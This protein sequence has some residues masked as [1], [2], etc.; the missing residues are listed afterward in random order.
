MR[1]AEFLGTR[2]FSKLNHAVGPQ[3]EHSSQETKVPLLQRYTR[4]MDRIGLG[5]FQWVMARCNSCSGIITKNDV[6]CYVCGEPVEEPRPAWRSLFRIW[7]KPKSPS[8]YGRAKNAILHGSRPPQAL[9]EAAKA[10]TR[11]AQPLTHS[12]P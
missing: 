9:T 5:G 10:A 3:A 6:T 12:S 2:F 11:I 1:P 4:T 7:A 8:E